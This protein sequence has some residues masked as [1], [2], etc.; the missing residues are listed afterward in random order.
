MFSSF[1]N[2]LKKDQ[3]DR[4]NL[5]AKQNAVSIVWLEL[6]ILSELDK[7]IEALALKVTVDLLQ[8]VLFGHCAQPEEVVYTWKEVS[9]RGR[10]TLLPANSCQIAAG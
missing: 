3:E 5:R 4:I 1:L 10:L 6:A 7:G 9:Q 2:K 8:L